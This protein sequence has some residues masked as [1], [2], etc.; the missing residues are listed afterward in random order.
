MRVLMKGHCLEAGP[1][2]PWNTSLFGCKRCL[3]PTSEVFDQIEGGWRVRPNLCVGMRSW[4]E[5]GK[6]LS[7]EFGPNQ[8][9]RRAK[10]DKNCPDL[11]GSR[12]TLVNTSPRIWYVGQ[13]WPGFGQICLLAVGRVESLGLSLM[14]HLRIVVLRDHCHV[15]RW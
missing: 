3:R 1:L 10:P 6:H 9:L 5:F 7:F 15:A 2:Q 12:P 13:M 11:V 8:A 4:F 14:V